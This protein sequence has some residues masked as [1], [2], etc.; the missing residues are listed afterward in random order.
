MPVTLTIDDGGFQHAM[1]KMIGEASVAAQKMVTLGG[2]IIAANAKRAANGRPGPNVLTGSHRRSFGVHHVQGS[3]ATWESETGPTMAYS[4]RLELGFDGADS[5]GRVYR[6]PPYP[7]LRPGLEAS[8]PQ[9]AM[10]GRRLY[11]RV[12]SG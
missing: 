11:G 10:L 12:V 1:S 5:L 4:R 7:S 8:G 3:G 9:L 6:Q 2:Q